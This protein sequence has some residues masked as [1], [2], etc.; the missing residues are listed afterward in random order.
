MKDLSLKELRTALDKKEFSASELVDESLKQIADSDLNAFIT[1]AEEESKELA[2]A[3]D[4]EI[5][6]GKSQVLTGIPLGIKDL[7]LTK[8]QKATCASKILKDFVAPYEST[9]TSKLK[10]A[11]AICLGKTN[12]DE[13]AMG[14]SNE[15]SA[16]GAV[17][18]PWNKEKVPGGSSG[19][20]AAAV[21]AGLVPATLGTDTGGSIRQP[22]SFCSISGLKPT[23]GR[24]SRYGVTAYASSLDQVGPMA[25]NAEDLAIMLNVLAGKDALDSTS[26]DHGAVDFTK[27]LTQGIQGLKIGI[28]QE[29]FI[30]GIEDD[31]K[32]KVEAAIK[33][34]EKQGAEVKPVSL[35]NTA[36]AVSTYYIIAPAE[37]SSNLGRFDGIRYGARATGTEKLEELYEKSR[38]EGFGIEV[39]RRIL[40]GSY[41]LSAGYYDAYYLKAQ[42]VRRLIKQDFEATFNDCDILATPVAPT[43]AFGIGENIDDPITMYLND[44]FT[45]P[46]NLAG[47]PGASIPCGFDK[48][49]LPIGLQL[50]GKAW[51]EATILKTAHSYQQA[52]DWHLKTPNC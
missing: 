48:S 5:A 21:A 28:P 19:G 18:N 45:I 8:G 2:K 46:V 20:S 47:L 25:K 49:G 7:I 22:A 24:V 29:Y 10:A 1:V 35:P 16:F 4:Q 43:T 36:N 30:D 38:S 40:M 42:K 41:V 12:L 32:I 31:V 50:I 11:G 39:K 6:A 52:T 26:M 34:L 17:L 27:D 51:D 23:Y 9:V 13:F 14:S 44:I 33:E 37:A 15:T 3:A